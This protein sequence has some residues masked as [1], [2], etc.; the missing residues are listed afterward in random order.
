ML[1]DHDR[2]TLRELEHRLAAEDAAFVQ[3]F[4]AAGPPPRRNPWHGAGVAQFVGALTLGI[5]M[6]V[7]G[8]TAGAVA[9]LGGAA[10]VGLAWWYA[11]DPEAD[12]RSELG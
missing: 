5:V 11:Q 4:D 2:R 12:H 8:A 7:A 3:R 9:F 10:A 6:L 1:S